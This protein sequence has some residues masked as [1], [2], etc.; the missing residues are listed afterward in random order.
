MNGCLARYLTQSNTHFSFITFNIIWWY[1]VEYFL[2]AYISVSDVSFFSPIKKTT[3]ESRSFNG[4]TNNDFLYR[5]LTFYL[6]FIWCHSLSCLTS[7]EEWKAKMI[8]YL[9]THFPHYTLVL[10]GWVFSMLICVLLVWIL[11][12]CRSYL[13]YMFRHDNCLL[14]GNVLQPV[15]MEDTYTKNSRTRYSKQGRYIYSFWDY[16]QRYFNLTLFLK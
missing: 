6:V 4:S 14:D 3:T 11:Y 15:E 1:I 10:L 2:R 8:A 13:F 5:I 12:T 9:T 7:L 16:L